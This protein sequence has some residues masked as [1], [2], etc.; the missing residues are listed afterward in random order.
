MVKFRLSSC[1]NMYHELL[2]PYLTHQGMTLFLYRSPH[3]QER[4]DCFYHSRR[5]H[6]RK[7]P[8]R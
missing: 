3:L 2:V 6:G 7:E 5:R 8:Y 4:R 1:D